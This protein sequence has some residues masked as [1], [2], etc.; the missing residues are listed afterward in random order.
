MPD[1]KIADLI[2]RVERASG[3]DRVLDLDIHT[4]LC[5][6][7]YSGHWQWDDETRPPHLTGSLDA[8]LSLVERARPGI[9]WLI[10]RG[11][12]RSAEPPFG[13]Q[14][15]FATDE[16]LGQGEGQTAPLA[17]LSALLRSIQG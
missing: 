9:F 11:M 7:E 2:E 16:I 15:L 14:L 6:D 5:P 17:V 3:E 13:C 1:E 12:T 8:V 10:G 4:A